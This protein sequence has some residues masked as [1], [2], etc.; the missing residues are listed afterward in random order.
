MPMKVFNTFGVRWTFNTG[1]FT[2]KEHVVIT[3]S[4]TSDNFVS[5]AN[6]GI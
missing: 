4:N 6:R 2:I 5:L 1:P 3:A